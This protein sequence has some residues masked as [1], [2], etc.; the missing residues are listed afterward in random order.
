MPTSEIIRVVLIGVGATAVLDVW[1]AVL[2]ALGIQTLD[3]A[4]LGRW[5]GHTFK[6]SF[7]QPSIREA[8]PIAGERALGWLT[9]YVVGVVFAGLLFRTMGTAWSRNPSLLPA[10]VLGVLTVAFPLF[11]M[12]PAMGAGFAASKT[13]TPIRNCLRSI[14]NHTIFGVGLYLSAVVLDEIFSNSSWSNHHEK[15]GSDLAQRARPHRAH[16]TPVNR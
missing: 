5:V 11:V 13:P 9:H 16:R 1:L 12:Q 10:I 2:K 14:V 15:S 8:T 7:F 6:G 3:F 4:L